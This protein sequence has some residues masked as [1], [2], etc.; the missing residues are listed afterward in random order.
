MTGGWVEARAEDDGTSIGGGKADDSK[1]W[2]C[3]NRKWV[4]RHQN[5]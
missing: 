3:P 1:G 5:F 2:R 4:F